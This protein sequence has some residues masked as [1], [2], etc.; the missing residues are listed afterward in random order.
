[1]NHMWFPF[2]F[3]SVALAKLRCLQKITGGNLKE[4]NSMFILQHIKA[5]A[6]VLLDF[7]ASNFNCHN[8]FSHFYSIAYAFSEFGQMVESAIKRSPSN[9]LKTF[10]A[11][12]SLSFRFQWDKLFYNG[13]ILSNV[14][15]EKKK[16]AFYWRSVGYIMSST[17]CDVLLMM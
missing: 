15:P 6:F 7:L 13:A 16:S 9:C 12:I 1:M 10:K 17:L 14:R 3:R 11:G 4:H 5:I 8:L 2:V